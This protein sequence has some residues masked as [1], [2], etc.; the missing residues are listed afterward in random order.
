MTECTHNWIKGDPGW[1]RCYFCGETRPG[2]PPGTQTDKTHEYSSGM[3][4]TE[5]GGKVNYLLIRSG[6]MYERWAV[7]MTRGALGD[8]WLLAAGGEEL[9]HFRES[10][11][12]HMEQWIAG[13]TDE[14]HAAAIF[15][16]INGAE[17]VKERLRRETMESN[18]A[19][20]FGEGKKGNVPMS[21]LPQGF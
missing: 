13:K 20:L 21:K 4:R 18:A 1:I 6:P 7:H 3:R 16:N 14:D 17:Y 11:L 8:N 19:T 15:F 12:R 2:L 9:R 5:K 10:A